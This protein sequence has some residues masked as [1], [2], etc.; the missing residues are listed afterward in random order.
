[1]K[2]IFKKIGLVLLG[3]Y[4]VCEDA[5]SVFTTVVTR[6]ATQHRQHLR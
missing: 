1:M 4:P 3:R 6:N 5:D 2:S